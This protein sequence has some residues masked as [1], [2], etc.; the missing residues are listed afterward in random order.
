MLTESIEDTGVT[1]DWADCVKN[2]EDES[3]WMLEVI[4]AKHAVTVYG[5]PRRRLQV[6]LVRSVVR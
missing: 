4:V 5:R 3:D 6:K 2:A 1:V